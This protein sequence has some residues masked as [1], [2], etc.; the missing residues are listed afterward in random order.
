MAAKD[1]LKYGSVLVAMAG[2]VAVMVTIDNV[3]RDI[4]NKNS[5]DGIVIADDSY[6]LNEADGMVARETIP[7][8]ATE[9]E[10]TE[11][12][13]NAG[14]SE[15]TFSTADVYK[16]T[17][18]LYSTEHPAEENKSA[19]TVDLLDFKNEYYT[20]VDSE[21][22][23]D[24]DSAEAF[25]EMMEDYYEANQLTDFIVYGTTETYTGEGS[26]CPRQFAES[27]SGC[28]VDL[29]V[30][31]WDSVVSYDGTGTQ[32][33]IEENCYKY[34]FIV[35]YPQDKEALTG[36]SYCPWH[37]RYVG[38]PHSTI[39]HD[40]NLCLEEYVGALKEFTFDNPYT[41]TVDNTRYKIYTAFLT[42]G[43][44]TVMAPIGGKYDMSGNS[45][46][47]VIITCGN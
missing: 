44:S 3:R 37:L 10:A 30:N 45:S 8:D 5:T 11:G 40:K 25:N 16:G 28:C 12:V 14:F 29:A 17:L 33:W 32:S 4:F 23:L 18:A 1:K 26:Y 15:K 46:D 42:E 2:I 34:G 39:M 38:A 41:Y 7:M 36:E 19:V 20:L 22:E 13:K 27:P 47:G 35:R 9:A 6:F 24:A 31:G 21:V 43:S